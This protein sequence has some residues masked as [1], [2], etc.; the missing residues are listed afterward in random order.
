[1]TH[2]D[3]LIDQGFVNRMKTVD[4]GASGAMPLQHY[5]EGVFQ[6]ADDEALLVEA[7]LPDGADYYARPLTDRMR[8]T[9]D[10]RHEQP[11][12]N[13]SQGVVDA[14][15]VLRVVVSATDPGIANW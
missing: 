11:S 2:V 13:R 15:G 8:V 3:E 6:L 5:H 12:V 4:Y 1:M 7:H 10:W 14:D 9:L